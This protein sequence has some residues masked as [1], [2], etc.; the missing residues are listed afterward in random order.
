M[1]SGFILADYQKLFYLGRILLELRH[2]CSGTRPGWL[3]PFIPDRSTWAE[4]D[5][6]ITTPIPCTATSKTELYQQPLPE[7]HTRMCHSESKVELQQNGKYR[8]GEIMT[9]GTKYS[10]LALRS[11]ILP[12]NRLV[13]YLLVVPSIAMGL[14]TRVGR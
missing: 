11:W 10:P 12:F 8:N 2:F 6:D 3:G 14:T 13:Y 5:G 1:L 9:I 7:T 4:R